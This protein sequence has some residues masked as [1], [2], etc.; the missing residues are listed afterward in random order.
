MILTCTTTWLGNFRV[1][2][3]D[4]PSCCGSRT[5]RLFGLSFIC[6][7]SWSYN[8]TCLCVSVIYQ[9]SSISCC[10]LCWMLYILAMSGTFIIISHWN[11][12]A[13]RDFCMVWLT[14]H[15]DECTQVAS[16]LST[17]WLASFSLVGGL[18]CSIILRMSPIAVWFSCSTVTI[19]YGS[20]TVLTRTLWI[21][22]CLS[23]PWNS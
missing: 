6:Y 14:V 11:I 17:I 23:R 4:K 2:C 18:M 21:P 1:R 8:I 13:P 12:R 7:F 5:H 22:S 15:L 19:D 10:R 20:F 3:P 9:F 16:A